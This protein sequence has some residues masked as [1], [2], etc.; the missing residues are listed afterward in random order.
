MKGLEMKF[1]MLVLLFALASV[2]AVGASA[3]MI[4]YYELDENASDSVVSARSGNGYAGTL[5]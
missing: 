3:D 4:A 2:L 5:F 1:N